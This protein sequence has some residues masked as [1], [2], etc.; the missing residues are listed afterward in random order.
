MQGTVVNVPHFLFQNYFCFLKKLVVL[1]AVAVAVAIVIVT[2]LTLKYVDRYMFLPP[3]QCLH[4][5]MDGYVCDALKYN[6]N[7]KIC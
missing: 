2:N 4:M 1:V 3:I 6:K 7:K 5:G